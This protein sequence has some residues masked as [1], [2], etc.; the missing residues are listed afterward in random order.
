M[1]LSNCV[2]T[3]ICKAAF[4]K[5]IFDM[6]MLKVI[7]FICASLTGLIILHTT[8]YNKC[9]IRRNMY[10]WHKTGI[11]FAWCMQVNKE[12]LCNFLTSQRIPAAVGNCYS[13]HCVLTNVFES[14]LLNHVFWLNL[15]NNEAT[16]IKPILQSCS[17]FIYVFVSIDRFIGMAFLKLSLIQQT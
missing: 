16:L 9:I 1:L 3:H 11:G 5:I 7:M 6:L 2:F 8:Y 15:L 4:V 13:N 14:V 12:W 17:Y 10:T